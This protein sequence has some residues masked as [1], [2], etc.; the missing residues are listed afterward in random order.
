MTSYI[1][2]RLLLMIPTLFFVALLTFVVLNVVPGGPAATQMSSQGTEST[3][4]QESKESYRIFKEQF[5][6]DKPIVYNTRFWLGTE[7]VERKLET[8]AKSRQPAC[9][10]DGSGAKDCLP[11][12]EKP[13][14]SAVIEASEDLSDW[15]DYI[16]PELFEVAKNHDSLDVRRLAANQ[17]VANGQGTIVSNYTGSLTEEQQA[18]NDRI[19]SMN[20]EIEKWRVG[21]DAS[22]AEIDR[23]LEENW[24]PFLEKHQDRFTFSSDERFQAFFLDTRF[25]KYMMNL[26]TLDFGVSHV[27]KQPV[28]ETLWTK[29]QYTFALSF[30]A[31][32]LAFALSVPIGI[33]SASNQ[34]TWLDQGVTTVLLMLF[35]LPSFFTALLLLKFLAAGDPYWSIFPI[36][37]F[38]GDGW[39]KMTTVQYFGSICWHLFLPVLCLTYRRIAALSRYARTGIVDVIRSDYVRTARAKGLSEPMV[40]LKHAT[41]NGM[42]PIL[43]LLGTQLPRLIGG[44]IVI[45]VIFGIPGMG[46]YLFAS[47]GARDYNALMAVLL[48]S[49]LLTLIGILISDISYAI[50]DPR[51]SFD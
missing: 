15:G 14:T 28:I 11:P 6:L 43:T 30:S 34:D 44:S 7:T 13:P 31:I 24:K 8:L 9:P 4:S 36:D 20:Q 41:R 50:V 39:E 18:R 23:I 26:A 42:I 10:G 5:N 22:A 17:L 49:A 21:Q 25:A 2:K 12:E 40:I 45:E 48:I 46:S 33:W 32:F 3:T 27:D 51:I 35:S 29:V 38:V 19:F 37:G 47:I 16:V 1:V